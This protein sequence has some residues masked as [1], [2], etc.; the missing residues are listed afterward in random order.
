MRGAYRAKGADLVALLAALIQAVGVERSADEVK[1]GRSSS[2]RV[3]SIL[4]ITLT[5]E[6]WVVLVSLIL[7]QRSRARAAADAREA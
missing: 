6:N 7:G 1:A 2:P 4:P 3:G 5:S